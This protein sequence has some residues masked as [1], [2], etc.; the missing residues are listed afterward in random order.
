MNI[1]FDNIKQ[2]VTDKYYN[3]KTLEFDFNGYGDY[4]KAIYNVKQVEK[5]Y[6]RDIINKLKNN[7]HLFVYESIVDDSRHEYGS[8]IVGDNNVLSSDTYDKALTTDITVP[9]LKYTQDNIPDFDFT[10][11]EGTKL[12]CPMLL[13]NEFIKDIIFPGRENGKLVDV[14]CSLYFTNCSY[15]LYSKFGHD[16][17]HI[18]YNEENNNFTAFGLTSTKL[19]EKIEGIIENGIQTPLIFELYGT[20]LFPIYGRVEWFAAL[21]LKLP[22][23]PVCVIN[24]APKFSIDNLYP[25]SEMTLA[26][27]NE[28]LSPYIVVYDDAERKTGYIRNIG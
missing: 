9:A 20:N 21:Y 26:K 4:K 12:K 22:I 14:N 13:R 2:Y 24:A 7:N 16:Y 10:V 6:N 5:K 25:E 18:S 17:R 3:Y 19:K 11:P 1:L 15:E 28:F 23:I 27:L 8:E